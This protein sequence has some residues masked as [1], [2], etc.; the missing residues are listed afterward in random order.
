MS[1]REECNQPNHI[2]TLVRP[3]HFGQDWRVALVGPYTSTEGF[4]KTFV[5]AVLLA[6]T[7]SREAVEMAEALPCGIRTRNLC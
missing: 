5:K 7:T 1:H 4:G 6:I 3:T 2:I